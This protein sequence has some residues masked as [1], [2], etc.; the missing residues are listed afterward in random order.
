[1]TS[2]RTLAI[3]YTLHSWAGIVTGLL[4]FVVCVTGAL[5]V[6]KHEIDVWAN[7]M[8]KDL[9]RAERRVGP[10][11][12]LASL[13]RQYPAAKPQIVTLPSEGSPSWFVLTRVSEGDRER[14]KFVARADSGEVV[15]PVDSELGQFI[16]N[17]HV[18]LIFGP[19]WPVGFLGVA[20]LFLIATGFVIHRKVLLELFTLRWGRS[21]RTVIADVH[22]AAGV[23]GLPFHIVIAF[24]GAWLGLSPVFEQGYEQLTRRDE[25]APVGSKAAVTPAMAGTTAASPALSL[26]ALLA[27]VESDLPDFQ[28]LS[29]GLSDR[30]KPAPRIR[31]TGR[32]V[33]SVLGPVNVVYDPSGV[34]VEGD[35][36]TL[37]LWTRFDRLLESLHF[38]DF[39]GI[40]LKWLY[41]ALGLT[42][43]ALALSGA[44]AWLERRK[45]RQGAALGVDGHRSTALER[46]LIGLHTGA[47]AALGVVVAASLWRGRA[48][49]LLPQNAGAGPWLWLLLW[50][51]LAALISRARPLLAWRLGIG[52]C[53]LGL[54]LPASVGLVQRAPFAQAM[55]LSLL[56]LASACVAIGFASGRARARP[57]RRALASE[58]SAS[59]ARAQQHSPRERLQRAMPALLWLGCVVV[60]CVCF[61]WARIGAGAAVQGSGHVGMLLTFFVLIPAL[62][63]SRWFPRLAAA[64]WLSAALLFGLLS[65]RFGEP[66]PLAL[67]LV[68]LVGA[69]VLWRDQPRTVTDEVPA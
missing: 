36:R 23:W 50:L 17:I 33:G 18:F 30:D 4:V 69:G 6:F 29:I 5:L 43:A 42:P 66:G 68:V 45:I 20:V 39:G 12:V 57:L 9:P 60:F 53:A 49:E 10:E 40:V 31:F 28:V 44:L 62:G 64:L 47:V 16:R 52:A 2:R 34:L 54:L 7:P 67:S 13:E 41:L 26:D 59:E 21:S 37:G 38:G 15:G 24:S 19:R 55:A 35:P 3:L 27:R 1:M 63:L 58:G 11:A 51:V 32:R 22:R 65:L 48:L 46:W 25:P 61:A 14:A 8:L 56:L